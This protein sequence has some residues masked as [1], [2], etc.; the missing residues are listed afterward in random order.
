MLAQDKELA[1]RQNN[2][3]SYYPG[4]LNSCKRIK[5]NITLPG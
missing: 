3:A 1:L 5:Y 2:F 4:G